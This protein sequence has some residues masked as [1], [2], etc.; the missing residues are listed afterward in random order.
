MVDVKL[1]L[2]RY[3]YVKLMYSNLKKLC[4]KWTYNKKIWYY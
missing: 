4:N 2:S 3:I 1:Q